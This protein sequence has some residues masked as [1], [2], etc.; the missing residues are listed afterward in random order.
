MRF[1]SPAP[2]PASSAGCTSSSG[3]S[4]ALL[5]RIYEQLLAAFGPQ[6]WWPA[7]TPFEVCVGAVLTQ[8]TAWANVERAVANLKA[9]DRLSPER[10][11]VLSDTE[12][13]WLIRPAGYYNVKARRL[14]GFVRWLVQSGGVP[15]LRREPSQAL[16]ERLLAVAGVGEET[17]DSMLVYAFGRPS[18]VIDAYTR[19]I[20]YR[21]GIANGR[22][23]YAE[24]K[25]LF[26]T[27]LPASVRVF[28]EFHAL[29][30]RLGKE[31]CRPTPVCAGCPLAVD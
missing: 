13:A 24:L 15:A 23:S 2:N 8:N 20:L 22:E 10:L 30:V 6:H 5:R 19:R 31:H 27:A 11:A 12:L 29:F 3:P 14:L 7:A 26:E 9:A 18:F 17:A 21:Y 4:R 28:N 16:R 1:S 25:A